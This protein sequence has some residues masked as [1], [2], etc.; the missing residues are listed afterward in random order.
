[1]CILLFIL[2]SVQKILTGLHYFLHVGSPV[3]FTVE[4]SGVAKASGDGLLCGQVGS[5]ASFRVL[6]PGLPGKPSIHVDGP[7]SVATCSI[8]R[9]ADGIYVVTYTPP[10]VGV[11]DVRVDWDDSPIPGK[12]NYF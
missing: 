5:P 6:G 2:Q 9:E 4:D 11:Y 10:E 7:D 3:T 12:R 8:E 1:M